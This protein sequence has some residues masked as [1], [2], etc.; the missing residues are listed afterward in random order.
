MIW[1]LPVSLFAVMMMAV[2]G[3]LLVVIFS[4][5][6]AVIISVVVLNSV[7]YI[8]LT[9]VSSNPQLLHYSKVFPKMITFKRSS[10]IHY[11]QD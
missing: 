11:E 1:G 10:N 9:R 8:G 7:L 3:S 2:I 6:F 4:F 5:S